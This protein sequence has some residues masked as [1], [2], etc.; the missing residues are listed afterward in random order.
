[1][2]LDIQMSSQERMGL[3]AQDWEIDLPLRPTET[4][5]YVDFPYEAF[6][7]SGRKRKATYSTKT[8]GGCRAKCEHGRPKGKCKDCGTLSVCAHGKNKSQ[9][10]DCGT[11]HCTHGRQKS[12]CRLC[13]T[14]HCTHGRRKDRCKDCGTGVGGVG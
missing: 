14:G 1:M 9:C 12:Q 13:G 3:D 7:S 10:R 6:K 4:K 2:T 8:P 11:G 5:P